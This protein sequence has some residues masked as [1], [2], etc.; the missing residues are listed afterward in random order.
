M[1]YCSQSVLDPTGG[2]P[3][4]AID[5]EVE[6][7][8]AFGLAALGLSPWVLSVRLQRTISVL[9]L[10]VGLRAQKLP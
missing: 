6:G 3:A 2:R 1:W 9:K 7:L 8:V 5:A 10:V 4:C